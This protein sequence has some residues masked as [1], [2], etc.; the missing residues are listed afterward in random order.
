[1]P[2]C[3]ITLSENSP[4]LNDQQMK[5][6]RKIIAKGL[7]SNSRKLDETHIAMRQQY[8]KRECMLGDIEIDIF[9]Q[10]YLRRLFSRDKRA[11]F[12]SKHISS[13]LGCCCATWINMGFVGYSRVATS[14]D[15]FYSDSDNPFIRGIQ[16]MRGISTKQKI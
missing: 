5:Q 6:V 8:G 4:K 15:T 10:L 12:I 11:N 13:Y 2:V 9:S 1:M 7:D 16:K 14:G 3:Y